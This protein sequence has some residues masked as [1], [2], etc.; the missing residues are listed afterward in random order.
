MHRPTPSL[1]RRAALLV[2]LGAAAAG[3]WSAEPATGTSS[4]E[5]LPPPVGG[6]GPPSSGS[7]FTWTQMPSGTTSALTAVWGTSGTNVY[8]VGYDGTLL[9]YDGAA[10]TRQ[11]LGDA[12]TTHLAVWGSSATSVFVV[13]GGGRVFHWDGAAWGEVGTPTQEDLNAVWGT[14]SSNVWAVGTNGA[15]LHYDGLAWSA[16]TSPTTE[17]L[18]DVWG[19]SATDVW[20]VG[21]LQTILHYDGTSWKL[22]AGPA[23]AGVD[24]T[25][26][27]GL[28]TTATF[29]A[30]YGTTLLS[31]SGTTTWTTLSRDGTL[32]FESLWARAANDVY[33]AA[34]FEGLYHWDGA[35][36]TAVPNTPRVGLSAIWATGSE[37]FAVGPEGVVLHATTP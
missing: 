33:A 37:A 36:W 28:G 16:V 12:F 27:T 7:G 34:A 4:L 26:V 1:L 8:A 15:I 22:V 19:N 25:A 3:C 14:S 5:E 2:G 30:G 23:P 31:R 21:N 20:A 13:G 24:Y 32:S 35:A 6:G 29:I 10:W 11:T 18:R 9:H 17:H